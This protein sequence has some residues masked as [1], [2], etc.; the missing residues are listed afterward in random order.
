VTFVFFDTSKKE[1]SMSIR[2]RGELT[3]IRKF[4]VNATIVGIALRLYNSM[5]IRNSGGPLLVVGQESIDSVRKPYGF[6]HFSMSISL[7]LPSDIREAEAKIFSQSQYS[8]APFATGQ[9]G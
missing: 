3:L 9:A 4:V 7:F 5:N 1:K 2:E 8:V 6:L